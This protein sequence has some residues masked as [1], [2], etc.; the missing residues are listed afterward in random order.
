MNW[1]DRTD[2]TGRI[3]F[4]RGL[5]LSLALLP[6]TI[7]GCLLG[8]DGDTDI[9]N[10]DEVGTET[11][12]ETETTGDTSTETETTGDTSTETQ[13]EETETETQGEETETQGDTGELPED[14]EQACADACANYELCDDEPSDIC[15]AECIEE[16]IDLQETP[17]CFDADVALLACVGALSC[18]DL[19]HYYEEDVSPYPCETEEALAE[20][21]CDELGE[22]C[23]GVIGVGENPGDCSITQECVDQPVFAIECVDGMGCTCTLGGVEVG[24]CDQDAEV[25]ANPADEDVIFDCCDL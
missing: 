16:I 14:A 25:C 20:E 5:V 10:D 15:Y 3:F 9:G 22:E 12:T 17:E 6:L 4:A 13:G 1:I 2:R 11:E 24:T 19:D 21:V 23:D 18:E 8:D 7:S